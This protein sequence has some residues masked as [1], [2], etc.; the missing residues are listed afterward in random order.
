MKKFKILD[1]L[2]VELTKKGEETIFHIENS[3]T[4]E[5]DKKIL[6]KE[7]VETAF[8]LADVL[9]LQKIVKDQK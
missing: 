6:K 1:E 8:R 7:L 4:S 9:L 3:D 2:E 5:E